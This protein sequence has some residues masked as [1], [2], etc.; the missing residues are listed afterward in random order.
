MLAGELAPDELH[1]QTVLRG[2]GEWSKSP[3]NSTIA[4]DLCSSSR[5]LQIWEHFVDWLPVP[6]VLDLA[7]QVLDVLRRRD[8]ANASGGIE[9]NVVIALWGLANRKVPKNDSSRDGRFEQIGRS[10]PTGLR[11]VNDLYCYWGSIQYGVIA[12]VQDRNLVR[13]TIVAQAKRVFAVDKPDV[14]VQSLSPGYP[15]SVRQL[16]TPVDQKEPPSILTRPSDWRWLCPILLAAATRAPS[17]SSPKSCS[18]LQITALTQA[19]ESALVIGIGNSWMGC[20]GP[21]FHA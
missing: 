3:S 10:M 2:M 15:Y 21:T 7:G 11:L 19:R 18:S 9:A 17:G 12:N 6:N 4:S 13:E 14:L 20:L 8:R 16:V 1:D 5:F